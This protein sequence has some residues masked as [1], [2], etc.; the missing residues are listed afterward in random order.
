MVVA[1]V[2]RALGRMVVDG[3]WANRRFIVQ[4]TDVVGI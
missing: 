2:M 4:I 1:A 3:E